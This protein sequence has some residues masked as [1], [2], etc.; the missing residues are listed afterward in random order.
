L[1]NNGKYKRSKISL[2]INGITIEFFKRISKE[3]FDSINKFEN[4]IE[5]KNVLQSKLVFTDIESVNVYTPRW[6]NA[7]PPS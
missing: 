7:P 6:L 5:K 4:G 3:N 2:K 1:K